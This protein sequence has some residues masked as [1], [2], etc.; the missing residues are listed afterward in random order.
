MPSPFPNDADFLARL[1]DHGYV[2]VFPPILQPAGV[3]IDVLGE[4]LRR[5]MFLT[6]DADGTEMCLRPDLT[7]PTALEHIGT[8]RPNAEAAYCYLGPAFRHREAGHGEFLQGGIE[9]FGRQDREAADAEILSRAAEAIDFYG[10]DGAELRIGDRA[11]F[12]AFIDALDIPAGWQRRLLRDTNG[13]GALGRDV[14]ALTPAS[15]SNGDHTAFLAALDGADPKAAKAVVEDLLA[16]AGIS[17]VGGRTAGDIAER[18]LEQARLRATSIL[19]TVTHEALT[20]FLAI[21]GDPVSALG[22]IRAL[23]VDAR[24][25]GAL[26]SGDDEAAPLRAAL[27]SFETRTEL[28]RQAGLDIEAIRFSTAFGRQL[29]Y[30]T[31]LVF[32]FRVPL[33]PELGPLVG[34]GRYDDLIR[35]LGAEAS[36]PAVGCAIFVERIKEA[37]L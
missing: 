2:R 28:M 24:L 16:I 20:A 36:A 14:A 15:G 29:D 34:G 17:Q 4:D 5:R 11:L 33:R 12:N 8:G 10:I 22:D 32:E 27:D 26:S 31:G 19:P 6:V 13:D 25:S 7:I 30:Y 37:M 9:I 18:F 23:I 21:Q 35:Q 1:T 3:F